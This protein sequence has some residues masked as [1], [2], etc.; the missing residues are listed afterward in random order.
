MIHQRA[1]S[2]PKEA[3]LK[4]TRVHFDSVLVAVDMSPFSA[5]TLKIAAELAQRSDSRLVVA[6]VIDPTLVLPSEAAQRMR[7][8]ISIFG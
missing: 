4:T 7:R 5:N 6:H 3:H 2:S 8:I 1:L